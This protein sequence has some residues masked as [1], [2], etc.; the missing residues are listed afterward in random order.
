[1]SRAS[2]HPTPPDNSA[3]I[4]I[5]E[6]MKSIPSSAWNKTR[7]LCFLRQ[8]VLAY[9]P[10]P[11]RL[12]VL[13]AKLQWPDFIHSGINWFTDI[14]TNIARLQGSVGNVDETTTIGLVSESALPTL[15]KFLVFNGCYHTERRPQYA[16]LCLG[17]MVLQR[18]NMRRKKH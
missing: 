14:D 16:E 7:A 18:K 3:P 9:F 6:T 13:A 2:P 11:P 5:A 12:K 15:L 8:L 17:S 1:M 10:L 4:A